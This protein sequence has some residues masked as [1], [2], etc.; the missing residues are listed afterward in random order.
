[1]L[2]FQAIQQREKE[3][4]ELR[5]AIW[6]APTCTQHGRDRIMVCEHCG[7]AFCTGCQ[8]PCQCENE[9]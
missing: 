8:G 9:E 2:N 7:I 4:T 5:V 3:L 1:M 6:R